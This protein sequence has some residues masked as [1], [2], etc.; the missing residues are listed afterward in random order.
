MNPTTAT[1]KPFQ[2]GSIQHHVEMGQ[3]VQSTRT[4]HP[5]VIYTLRIAEDENG[6]AM[7]QAMSA[8]SSASEE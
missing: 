4:V 6:L 5:S 3:H 1:T 8:K 2:H 7:K